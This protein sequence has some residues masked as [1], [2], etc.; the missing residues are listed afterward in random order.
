MPLQGGDGKVRV[1]SAE[2]VILQ[3]LYPAVRLIIDGREAQL[4]TAQKRSVRE[5]GFVF[6]GADWA[7]R[8]PPVTFPP[9]PANSRFA[10]EQHRGFTSD[11]QVIE[12]YDQFRTDLD[13]GTFEPGPL[14][15]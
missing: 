3:G 15:L 11:P 9:D 5:M 13:R 6:L 1:G 12:I 7:D 10:P 4:D 14:P 8:V 2:Y